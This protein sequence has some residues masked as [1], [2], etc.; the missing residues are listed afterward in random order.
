MILSEN[1]S[2]QLSPVIAEHF[3]HASALSDVFR[4]WSQE[5]ALKA[6]WVEHYTQPVATNAMYEMLG[7]SEIVDEVSL[8]TA[9]RKLRKAVIGRLILRDLNG[10][11]DLTEVMQTTSALAEVALQTANRYLSVW[12][13]ETYGQPAFSQIMPDQ[14]QSLVIV[15]MGKLGGFELNVSSDIDLIFTYESNGV[16]DGEQSLSHQEFFTRLAKQLISAIDEVTAD[17]FVFRVDM[18]LRPFGSEGPL[19]CSFDA[20]ESYYQQYGREWERYAWIKGRVITGHN[21]VE[22]MLKPFIYRKYLDFGTLDSMRDLKKQIHDGVIRGDMH[23]NIKIGRGGIREIEFIAQAFQLMRG[24]HEIT[25]QVKPTLIALQSMVSIG[26]ITQEEVDQLSEA[27]TFFRNLEHRLQYYQ[28]QQT[29]VLPK[30]AQAQ[31]IIAQSM[32]FDDWESLMD[33][34]SQYREFVAKEFDKIFAN[35]PEQVE[36]AEDAV[37][38]WEKT[39]SEP[40]SEQCFTNLGYSDAQHAYKQ[41]TTFKTSHHYKRLPEV[42]LRRINALMPNVVAGCGRHESANDCLQRMVL[43]IE[44]ICLRA[45]Y[46]A[47][48]TEYPHVLARLISLV[49]ASPWVAQYLG[50][51][52]ILLDSLSVNNV[53]DAEGGFDLATLETQVL[54][55]LDWLDG[56]V[57]Q[58]MNALRDFQQQQLFAVA[59]QDVIEEIPIQ[60]LSDLLSQLADLILRVV[61]KVVWPTVKGAHREQP[62]FA[63]IAYGKHGGRELSYLSD[64]DLVFVYD[65]DYPGAREVYSRFGM[66]I[67]SWLNTMTSS[68]ILYE[69]DMQLRPDGNSGLLV[70]SVDGFARYQQEKAWVWEHQAMTRARFAEGDAAVGAA[71]EA[72]REQT[73]LQARDLDDLK[74]QVLDMRERMKN[75]YRYVEGQFDLKKSLGG[76]V[77]VEFI[78][79]YLILAHAHRYPQLL[80]NIGNVKILNACSEVGL[81]PQA[82]AQ[83]TGEAYIAL[84]RQQHVIRLQGIAD[85]KVQESSML[86][87]VNTVRELWEFVFYSD[88]V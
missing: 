88:K 30:H 83:T 25:L 24:G 21:D 58:Q 16:T 13:S 9:L 35:E 44:A 62:Q 66:K 60:R 28:D 68:G 19:V 75:A 43:L 53:F 15:G 81:I 73:L 23:D 3:E 7:A 65:D 55:K 6:H 2:P 42:S 54:E 77:D 57:E 64:L 37:L 22:R 52:P 61:M 40:E 71:F 70:I 1:N 49:G 41:L 26:L 72:V 69:V 8:K 20:M 86:A 32:Q 56:D 31:S 39:L 10:L 29:H 38:V 17:G 36:I 48:L 79:Q 46:I 11:A 80:K 78:V 50:Q 74:K 14:R 67:I 45:S 12:L 85:P 51:H 34:L 18:R 5:E 33:Q 84:R 63:V 47:F 76:M 82:L 87:L 59:S 27:Y 4:M